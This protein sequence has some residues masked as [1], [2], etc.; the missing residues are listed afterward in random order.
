MQTV[1]ETIDVE[2]P[3]RPA[4]DQWTQFESF[5]HFMS[6]WSRSPNSQTGRTAGW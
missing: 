5:P 2:V 6:D 1:E 3:V 4:Y